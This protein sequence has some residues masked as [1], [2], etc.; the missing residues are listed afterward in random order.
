MEIEIP[1]GAFDSE[2]MHQEITIPEGFEATIE[3][4]KIILTKTESED[5]RIR[6]ELLEIFKENKGPIYISLTPQKKNFLISLLEKQGGQNDSDVKDY[7]SIDPHFGKPIDKVEPKFKVGD[8]V[9]WDNKISCHID[10]IYQGKESLMYTITD[11]QNM[12]R[13]YSVKGFDNNAHLWTIND[14]RDGDVL[15]D[16]GYPCI[17]KSINEGNSMFVYCGIKGNR[18]FATKA[19]SEDNIWDDEPE[20]YCPATKEQRDTL[21]AKMKESGYKWNA[22]KKELEKIED[23]EYNGEDYGID[24]LWHAMNILEKT[25]G[26]VSGYQTDDG[27]LSHQCA[28]TS[29]KKL[30]KQK[31]DW[32]EEDE[33]IYQSII[34]DTV[35]ENQL[36]SKQIDWLKSIK[37]R[38]QPKQEWS[39]DDEQYLLVCKNALSKYQV[40]DKWDSS[41]ISQWLDNRLKS[42]K[43]RAF[44]QQQEWSEEEKGNVDI[45]VSRLEVDIEYWK[46]RSKRRIDEDK[47]VIDWLKSLRP[48]NRW[49]P[50]D[51]QMLALKEAEGIVGCLTIIGEQLKSLYQDLKKL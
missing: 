51:E 30:Y 20:N 42:L 7:N 26:K 40:T 33:R 37:S 49:K 12:T 14:A 35:Q 38:V 2:L 3:G 21:F 48:Q 44:P 31:P 4:N 32:G 11:A 27:F 39:E 5:E 25:L 23:E 34:D 13:S 1:F 9:V 36:D 45:I 29:V 47:R 19:D 28:I 18:N 22:E 24:G 17:F 8:W 15:T 10:N 41:I 6:K 46:S 16:G 43:D 50:S